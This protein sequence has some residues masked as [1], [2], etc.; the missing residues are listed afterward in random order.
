MSSWPCLVAK[1]MV[2]KNPLVINVKKELPC[3][4]YTDTTPIICNFSIPSPPMRSCSPVSCVMHWTCVWNMCW[5]EQL[6]K[7][8]KCWFCWFVLTEKMIFFQD[9]WFFFEKTVH[10]WDYNSWKNHPQPRAS[11]QVSA[12]LAKKQTVSQSNLK[13]PWGSN[14]TQ[15][16]IIIF[17]F[18]IISSP[19]SP[20]PPTTLPNF[21]KDYDLERPPSKMPGAKELR[22]FRTGA[23]AKVNTLRRGTSGDFLVANCNKSCESKGF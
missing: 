7:G 2:P 5:R 8:L 19:N 12:L 22:R 9:A 11:D 16:G 4:V 10:S 23:G 17:I 3:W 20:N 14:P 15:L 18:I 21:T 1:L 13:K 6:G